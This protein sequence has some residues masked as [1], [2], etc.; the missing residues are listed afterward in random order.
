MR[1]LPCHLLSAKA[2]KRCGQSSPVLFSLVRQQHHLCFSAQAKKSLQGGRL[3]INSPPGTPEGVRGARERAL[4][5]YG[6]ND[7]PIHEARGDSASSE[8]YNVRQSPGKPVSVQEHQGT[9]KDA[10]EGEVFYET[11]HRK[12]EP[13][14][15]VDG[16]CDRTPKR[17]RRWVTS[18]FTVSAFCGC[19]L[20]CG[21]DSPGITASGYSV[22]EN[23][24][25]FISAPK[26]FKFGTAF[27]IPGYYNGDPVPVL[28]RGGAITGNRLEVFFPLHSDARKWGRQI[29]QV[30]YLKGQNDE[31]TDLR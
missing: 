11:I 24:G 8:F 25:R 29:L 10:R 14:G 23:H 3:H 12:K 15:G 22:R 13:K 2:N 21:S 7:R 20:C 4:D 18:I 9:R 19:V 5:C 17:T 28:D 16:V 6:E 26:R 30:Q 31:N 1:G 27:R